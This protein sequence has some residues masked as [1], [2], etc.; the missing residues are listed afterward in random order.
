MLKILDRNKVP[1]KGLKKYDDLCIESVLELDD[2]T[3]SFAPY[4][5]IR[6]AVVK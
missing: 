2:R 4:R 5:N 6:N 3:L 1:V